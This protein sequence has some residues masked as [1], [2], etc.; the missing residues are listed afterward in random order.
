MHEYSL[1]R[2]LL[3]QVQAILQ[4][5]GS[6]KAT[7]ITVAIGPLAGVEPVL[8]QQ[9]FEQL[10]PSFGVSDAEMAIRQPVLTARCNDCKHDFEVIRFL[11]QCPLCQSREVR[12]ISGEEIRLLDI[13][14]IE[15][16]E[17]PI[18]KQAETR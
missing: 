15:E 11:F 2:S 16:R 3:R 10:A 18:A 9:A 8:F 17:A 5:E 7:E 4:H 14:V 6:V 1:V 12:V 13:T